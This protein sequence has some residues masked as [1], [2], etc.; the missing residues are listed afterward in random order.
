MRRGNEPHGAIPA[1]Y[2]SGLANQTPSNSKPDRGI[3]GAIAQ[4]SQARFRW[5]GV[6]FESGVLN[7]SRRMEDQ[8]NDPE[9]ERNEMKLMAFDRSISHDGT[10]SDPF[11]TSLM[12]STRSLDKVARLRLELFDS[13]SQLRRP[14]SVGFY[15]ADLKFV[16]PFASR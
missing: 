13:S 12:R 16:K 2:Q 1:N 6:Q 11:V 5:I 4:G 10:T 14:L 3:G 15:V 7:I 9:E 8:G